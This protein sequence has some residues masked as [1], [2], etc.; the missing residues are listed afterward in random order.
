LGPV[1]AANRRS[2]SQSRR[3]PRTGEDGNRRLENQAELLR[4]LADEIEAV[5]AERRTTLREVRE[6]L[7]PSKRDVVVRAAARLQTDDAEALLELR[8][9][10]HSSAR[11]VRLSVEILAHH[12]HTLSALL[13]EACR[14]PSRS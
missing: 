7:P 11:R 8:R 12:V 14:R 4:R 5:C 13:G 3:R 6:A 1:T 9:R 10:L 2:A